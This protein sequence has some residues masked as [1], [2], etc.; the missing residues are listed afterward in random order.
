VM[1]ERCFDAMWMDLKKFER[2]PAV[3]EYESFV[4]LRNVPYSVGLSILLPHEW[5]SGRAGRRS[6]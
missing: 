2:R 1:P 3:I 4:I 5:R 6:G